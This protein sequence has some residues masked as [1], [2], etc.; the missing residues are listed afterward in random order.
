MGNRFGLDIGSNSVKAVQIAKNGQTISLVAAGMIKSPP[1]VF[2]SDSEKDLVTLAEAIKKLVSE[3]N[4][5]ANEAVVA[6]PERHVFTQVFEFP[7]MKEDD[8]NQAIPWEAENLIPKPLSEVNLDWEVIDDE[9]SRK[10]GKVRVLLIA[11]PKELVNKY[12]KVLKLA[13]LVP[14]ALETELLAILRCLRPMVKDK[15]LAIANLGAGSCDIAIIKR[16][17]FYNTR[18]LP[19][20]G[21]A[22]TRGLSSSLG[23]DLQVA[24]EYKK[25]YG[26]T[27]QVE[28][29]VSAEIEPLLTVV[30]NEDKKAISFYEG[31]EKDRLG[32]LVLTGG[33][34]LLPGISEFF[35]RQLGIEVQ[36]ADPFSLVSL[37]GQ[38][39][40]ELKKS[41]P[42]YTVALGLAMK[43]G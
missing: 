37:D 34:C 28:G 10:A 20:A 6:I 32:L 26:L 11:S 40:L 8:L 35:T 7:E 31:K 30:A 25:T 21:E 12:T 33:T 23:L 22:I 41:S 18:S 24:E 15:S 43:E 2:S 13:N 3:A 4:I 27:A 14:A 9:D 5:R 19:T 17:Y 1:N 16:G 38:I 42:L 39:P 29:K 36:V